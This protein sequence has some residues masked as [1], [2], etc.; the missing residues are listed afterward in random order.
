MSIN[1]FQY[2]NIATFLLVSGDDQP[3]FP[4]I[5]DKGAYNWGGGNTD[6]TSVMPLSHALAATSYNWGEGNTGH[7]SVMPLGH[8]A[9]LHS[10]F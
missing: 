4:S 10:G 6:H 5:A 1:L 2:L 3:I 9:L 8:G 7:T